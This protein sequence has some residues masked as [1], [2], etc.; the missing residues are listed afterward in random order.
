MRERLQTLS[1]EKLKE[2]AKGEG[3]KGYSSMRKAE[4]IDLLCRKAEEKEGGTAAEAV[5][6]GNQGTVQEQA[7]HSEK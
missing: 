3:I 2:F 7:G 6:S 4:L 1:L 5:S